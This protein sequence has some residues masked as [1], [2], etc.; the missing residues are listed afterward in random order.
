MLATFPTTDC[1]ERMNRRWAMVGSLLGAAIV[2]AGLTWVA[3]HFDNSVKLIS[4]V[5]PIL[6]VSLAFFAVHMWRVQLVV[7]RRFEIAEEALQISKQAVYAFSAIRSVGGFSNEGETRKR[8]L[9]ET[10]DESER[11]DHAFVPFE[12]M[13]RFNEVFATVTKSAMLVEIHFGT[14]LANHMRDLLDIRSEIALAA[15]GME[16]MSRKDMPSDHDEKRMNKYM[17][18]L[19]EGYGDETEE[20]KD[21]LTPRIKAAFNAIETECRK[22][23]AI[24]TFWSSARL[25]S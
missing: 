23:L 25:W 5:S 12:R 21:V 20:H 8:G 7:K 15:R 2:V 11:L 9:N 24:P 14:A 19:Y 13:N 22:H 10:P 6:T 18:A 3:C 4:A 16:R 17:A 1:G